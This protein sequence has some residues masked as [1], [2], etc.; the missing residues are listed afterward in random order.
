MVLQD[1]PPSKDVR[2]SFQSQTKVRRRVDEPLS[3]LGASFLVARGTISLVRRAACAFPLAILIPDCYQSCLKAVHS[4]E[5]CRAN[6]LLTF[7]SFAF[8]SGIISPELRRCASRQ[9][10]C[11][12]APNVLSVQNNV[13]EKRKKKEREKKSVLFVIEAQAL[14]GDPRLGP[15][16]T[17]SRD[18]TLV[19]SQSGSQV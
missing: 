9:H 12:R 4:T 11:S 5:P 15:G 19:V 2:P 17:E 3:A 18:S 1:P 14:N 7:P 16:T 10:P 8:L 13:K 6:D